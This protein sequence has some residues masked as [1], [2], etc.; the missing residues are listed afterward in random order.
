VEEDPVAELETTADAGVM[1]QQTAPRIANS[2]P[3]Q[4]PTAGLVVMTAPKSIVAIPVNTNY[5]DTKIHQPQ[6]IQREAP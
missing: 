2:L 3:T 4:I 5:R 1:A 6:L